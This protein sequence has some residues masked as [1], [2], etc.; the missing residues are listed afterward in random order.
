[1]KGDRKHPGTH[2]RSELDGFRPWLVAAA[3]YNF[4]AGIT[5]VFAPALYFRVVH[6]PPPNYPALWQVLGMFILVYS[7]GYW[8]AS[9]DPVGNSRFV[10]IGLL[11][12]LLGPIGF[13]WSAWTGQLPLVFGAILVTNDLVWW[14]AFFAFASRAARL[15]GGWR[16]Y[17]GGATVVRS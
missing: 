4:F 1:M 6:I 2:P 7:P 13:I 14:P 5:I 11:G 9:R 16:P 15:S 10:V 3:V 12:K 17:L 8:W